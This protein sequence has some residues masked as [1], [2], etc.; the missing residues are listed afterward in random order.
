MD[1]G[2]SFSGFKLTTQLHLVPRSRMLEAILPLPQ[3]A[4]TAWCSVKKK[5]KNSFSFT[6][7]MNT[8]ARKALS[9]KQ[10]LAQKN[11]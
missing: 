7:T 1:T 2:G 4:F 6:F 8:P 9:V 10:F 11:D 3:Y 5:H